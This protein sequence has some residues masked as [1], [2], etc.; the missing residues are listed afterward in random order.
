M[1]CTKTKTTKLLSLNS[2]VPGHVEVVY[3]DYLSLAQKD[4]IVAEIC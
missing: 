1:I 3:I 4:L 2:F